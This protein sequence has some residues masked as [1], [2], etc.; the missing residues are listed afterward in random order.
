VSVGALHC[1]ALHICA[2]ERIQSVYELIKDAITV[3]NDTYCP[4]HT[5]TLYYTALYY[6]ALYYIALIALFP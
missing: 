2:T 4:H 1:T 3:R 5:F 6:I